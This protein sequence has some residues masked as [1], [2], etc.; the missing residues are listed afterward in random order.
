MA[1]PLPVSNDIASWKFLSRRLARSFRHRAPTA[2]EM[3]LMGDVFQEFV[4]AYPQYLYRFYPLPPVWPYNGYAYWCNKFS[5]I[6]GQVDTH[7]SG[8]LLIALTNLCNG[9]DASRYTT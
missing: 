1:V 6:I 7:I 9:L 4:W 5:H 2:A 3:L 8:D